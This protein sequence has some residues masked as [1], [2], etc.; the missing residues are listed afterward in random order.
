MKY[1][2]D[3]HLG[4]FFLGLTLALI[5]VAG[6]LFY[7]DAYLSA[8]SISLIAV[9]NAFVGYSKSNEDIDNIFSK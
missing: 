9:L 2:T 7:F 6:L 5:A 3:E 8:A 4:E 1:V